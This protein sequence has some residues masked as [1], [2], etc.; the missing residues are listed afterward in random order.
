[1]KQEKTQTKLPQSKASVIV[2]WVVTIATTCFLSIAFFYWTIVPYMQSGEYLSDERDAMSSGDFST[3]TSD[4][5][6]FDPDTNVEGILRSDFVREISSQIS[7]GDGVKMLP[8]LDKAI[9]EL[10]DYTQNHPGYYTYILTLANGYSVK[11][12]ITNDQSYYAKADDLY[13]KDMLL[14]PNRQD[15]IYSYAMDLMRQNRD[16]EAEDLLR[17]TTVSDPDTYATYYQLGE[18]YLLTDDLHTQESL[19]NFEIALS[20]GVNPNADFTKNAY[21]R[22]LKYYY[23]KKD[24]NNF[25]AVVSRLEEIDPPQKYAYE[26]V[27]GYMKQNNKIPDLNIASN[28]K[29]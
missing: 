10:E 20:H 17:K 4:Q 28:N 25:L 23:E 2:F 9:A 8:L 15:I 3:M 12:Q 1:M 6:L 19:D 7:K 14:V 11:G 27:I 22:F 16:S 18:V 13:K 26:G 5:F 21:Q 29:Q 24:F